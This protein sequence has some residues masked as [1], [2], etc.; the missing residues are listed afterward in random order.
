MSLRFRLLALILLILLPAAGLLSHTSTEQRRAASAEAWDSAIRLALLASSSQEQL[1]DMTR[2]LLG[3]LAAVPDVRD[4]RAAACNALVA[5]LLKQYPRY[6]NLGALTR[7]GD[8]FCSAVPLDRPA[9]AA[10]R[11][12]FWRAVVLRDFAVGDYVV[13]RVTDKPVILFGYPALDDQGHVVAVAF[14]A[15]DLGWLRQLVAGAHLPAGSMVTIVDRNGLVLAR[16]PNA[17][18]EVGTLAEPWLLRLLMG[19]R[20]VRTTEARGPDG[21][22]YLFA[23]SSLHYGAGASAYVSVG[24]S[25]AAAFAEADRRLKRDLMILGFVALLTLGTAWV[26]SDFAIVRRVRALV[27]ATRRLAA[28]DFSARSGLAHGRGELGQLARAFDQMAESLEQAEAQRAEQEELRR[29]NYELEQ[30]NAA[31]QE[32]DRMKSEFVSMVSHELRTPLTSIQ[33]SVDL[34][35]ARDAPTLR[36]EARELL[37]IVKNNA[38]RLL[39]LTNDLLDLARMEAGKMDPQRGSVDVAAAIR[40]VAGSL[41]PPIHSN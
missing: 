7:D 2:Q 29:K 25:K 12:F 15:L 26:G 13:G 39:V 32:A 1:V 23:F 36:E 30:Q 37:A 27:E 4:G 38:D 8:V 14:A 3:A 41:R 20:G 6:A 11:G 9:N 24:V 35:E 34:L 31:M 33:G 17:G 16:H 18:E 10:S 22:P 19:T 40:S 5:H 21:L 28:G